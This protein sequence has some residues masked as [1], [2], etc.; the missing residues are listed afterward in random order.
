MPFLFVDRYRMDFLES[1]LFVYWMYVYEQVS[2]KDIK[3]FHG[4]V[5]Q[6]RDFAF[7]RYEGRWAR[8]AVCNASQSSVD[9][10][11]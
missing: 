5:A 10:E 8:S 1:F 6:A 3:S 4:I 2:N 7:D 11:L 9:G